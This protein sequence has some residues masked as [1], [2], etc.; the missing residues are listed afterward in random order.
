MTSRAVTIAGYAAL[1][2]LG[3]V[4]TVAAR[5]RRTR[6]V[7][8]GRAVRTAVSGGRAARIA[9]VVLWAWL[10]WHFLARSG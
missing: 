7:P 6:L 3:A 10:G 4:L 8:V 2:V 1:F 5:V 9:V